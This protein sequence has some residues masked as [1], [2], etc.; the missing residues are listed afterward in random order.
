[1]LGR[2]RQAQRLAP[3]DQGHGVDLD[4]VGQ[5]EEDRHVAMFAHEVE[6]VQIMVRHNGLAAGVGRA[7]DERHDLVGGDEI[8]VGAQDPGAVRS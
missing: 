1:M 4:Q 3:V 6:A 7:G 2:D 8:D 5:V